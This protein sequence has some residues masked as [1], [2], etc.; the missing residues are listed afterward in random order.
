MVI[1]FYVIAEISG[2]LILNIV[3]YATPV[4]GSIASEHSPKD[5][6]ATNEKAAVLF[7]TKSFLEIVTTIR[8]LA[9]ALK[10]FS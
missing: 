2:M 7:L 3:E 10:V 8:Y 4:G 5:D 9:H 6:P 1:L